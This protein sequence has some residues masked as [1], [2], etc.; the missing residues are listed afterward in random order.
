MAPELIDGGGF[1]GLVGGCLELDLLDE[2]LKFGFA[3][4]REINDVW[5]HRSLI[6]WLMRSG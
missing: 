2:L 1:C 5:I 6:L 3:A 4:E